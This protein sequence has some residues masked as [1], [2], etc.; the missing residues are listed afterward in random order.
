MSTFH[1]M[2]IIVNNG[3]EHSSC[4][5]N[6]KVYCQKCKAMHHSALQTKPVFVVSA[7][8]LGLEL[9]MDIEKPKSASRSRI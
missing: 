4:Q 2:F 7:F 1:S 6:S 5:N 9:T 3:E 8:V